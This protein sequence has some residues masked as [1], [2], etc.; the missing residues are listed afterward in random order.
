RPA[1]GGHDSNCLP[2]APHYW[3]RAVGDDD[4]LT[5]DGHFG[6]SLSYRQRGYDFDL[7]P[8]RR[9]PQHGVGVACRNSTKRRG[10]WIKTHAPASR[11]DKN[12]AVLAPDL[13][14]R[15]FEILVARWNSRGGF[16]G[17]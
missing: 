3:P 4:S 9:R 10:A 14:S 15:E 8:E 1:G 16:V 7:A 12:N 2:G 11:T 17:T 13:T 5:R 6:W